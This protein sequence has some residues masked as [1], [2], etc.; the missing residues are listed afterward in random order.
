MTTVVW[1]FGVLLAVTSAKAPQAYV[2][3]DFRWTAGTA[4]QRFLYVERVVPNGPAARAGIRPGD[5]ITHMAGLPVDF[6]DE[7]DFLVF[8]RERKAHERLVV[9]ITR[10]G[11]SRDVVVILGALPEAARAAWEEGFRAAQQKR[12]AAR[13]RK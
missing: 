7:F 2:G 9:K 8:M 11:K 10:A 6:G 1:A 13:G 12:A 3:L 5:L 4:Q